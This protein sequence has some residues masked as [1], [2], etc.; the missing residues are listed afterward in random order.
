MYIRLLQARS[1]FY[2]PRV[3]PAGS[4][5]SIGDPRGAQLIAAG[6]A[7]PAVPPDDN[8]G[9]SCRRVH[10]ASPEP[11]D[12]DDAMPP[13]SAQANALVAA[14]GRRARRRRKNT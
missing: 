13:L 11:R 7:E 2:P 12:S 8:A 6:L 10:Y 14:L 5:H 3:E 4:V 1:I 9:D